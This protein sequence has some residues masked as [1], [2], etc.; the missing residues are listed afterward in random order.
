MAIRALQQR[1]HDFG[2][3]N[4]RMFRYRK[5]PYQSLKTCVLNGLVLFSFVFLIV[6]PT[7]ASML[8]SEDGWLTME[9][10]SVS[11]HKDQVKVSL[12]SPESPKELTSQSHC[13]LCCSNFSQYLV[14]TQTF[15][16]LSETPLV[17]FPALFYQSPQ[18]LF[19]WLSTPSRGPPQA[20]N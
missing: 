1:N 19:S 3:Y 4:F 12:G 2:V 16:F 15:I 7:F 8:V 5:H 11:G 18:P 9:I 6:A 13:Q 20:S 10:C 14:N 17:K